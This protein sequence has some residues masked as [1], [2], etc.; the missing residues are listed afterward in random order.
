MARLEA[1]LPNLN[2]AKLSGYMVERGC[3]PP[4]HTWA[5]RLCSRDQPNMEFLKELAFESALIQLSSPCLYNR[6]CDVD[7]HLNHL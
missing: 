5:P 7:E 3:M 1:K 4:W 2:T 6:A